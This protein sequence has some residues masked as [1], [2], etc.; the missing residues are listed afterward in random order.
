M[1]ARYI[2][3]GRDGTRVQSQGFGILPLG[4]V[5]SRHILKENGET[6]VRV[7]ESRLNFY[8]L[9]QMLLGAVTIPL[10]CIAY[11]LLVLPD[12]SLRIGLI[13]FGDVDNGRVLPLTTVEEQ[14]LVL[15]LSHRR[16]N[17]HQ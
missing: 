3:E 7:E 1:Q 10:A 8:R 17:Q 5:I 14:R 11:A 15:G 2:H 4:V 6:V 9:F 13:N 12:R 16:Q